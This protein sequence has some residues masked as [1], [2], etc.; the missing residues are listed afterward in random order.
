[1]L[2]ST[3]RGMRGATRRFVIA[4]VLASSMLLPAAGSVS[5]DPPS[6]NKNANLITLSCGTAGTFDAVIGAALQFLLVDST[7]TFVVT[8]LTDA[9]T[10]QRLFVVSG[11][12]RKS[13]QVTC[14]F[15]SPSGRS[16]RATGFFTPSS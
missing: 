1:M 2:R 10:G 14:T 13:N 15:T 8:S 16:F 9:T 7:N 5:A 12:Q 4:G 6:S 3:T 11:Q